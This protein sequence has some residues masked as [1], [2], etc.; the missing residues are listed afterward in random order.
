VTFA[1]LGPTEACT[2]DPARR[3]GNEFVF[4]MLAQQNI[5][6]LN[7]AG[8]AAGTGK[9]VIASCPHCFNAI[10]REYPQLG[11]NYEVIH[12]TQ[13]PAWSKTAS[14]LRPNPVSEKITYDGPCFL[15]RHNKVFTLPRQLIDAPRHH[16][17]R[18]APLREPRLLLRRRHV[19]GRTNQQ[20]DQ[21][22]THRR[23]PRP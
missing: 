7:D 5:E 17:R 4:T 15:G 22:R 20:A 21:R 6:T 2:G 1:V 8:L 12:H 16:R 18:N 13:L 3:L 19:A 14:L 11:G 9:K 10:A 23:G